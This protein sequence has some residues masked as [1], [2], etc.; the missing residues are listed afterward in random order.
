MDIALMR[1]SPIPPIKT[2]SLHFKLWINVRNVIF[3]SLICFFSTSSHA[4]DLSW[5]P[6]VDSEVEEEKKPDAAQDLRYG[7]VLYH[8]FQQ[9]YFDALTELMVGQ[10]KGDIIFHRDNAE[11]LRGG[12][13]LSYGLDR[14]AEPIFQRLLEKNRDSAERDTAWFYL[15]KLQHQR[16][17]DSQS[18]KALSQLSGNLPP[19]LTQESQSLKAN[20]LLQQGDLVSA[21]QVI[22]SLP[23]E[24]VWYPYYFYNL[25]VL[26]T[27]QGQWQQGVESL[28]RIKSLP[29]NSDELKILRDKAS[30]AIG[31]SY[32]TGGQYP[33][34]INSFQ[35]VRIN[36]PMVQKALLGYGWAEAQRGNYQAALSPWQKLSQLS[37]LNASVQESLLAIPY[38]YEKLNAAGSA[39]AYYENSV[40]KLELELKRLKSAIAQFESDPINELFSINSGFSD[41]WFV[42]DNL[43][44]NASSRNN[45]Y[46]SHLI[47]KNDFQLALKN[48][49]DMA[50]LL[51]NLHRARE[52]ALV[53]D[54]V[55]KD[56]LATWGKIV[57]QSQYQ[58][59]QDRQQALLDERE[60]LNSK[61]K[62]A[63]NVGDGFS[64]ADVQ[65]KD[66]WSRVQRVEGNLRFLQ[67]N[68]QTISE[69]V[70]KYR[71]L[72][73]MLVWKNSEELPQRIWDAKKQQRE[74]D[75][76]LA[77]TELAMASLLTAIEGYNQ[78]NFEQRM[79]TITERL[80]SSESST[81]MLLAESEQSLRKLAVSELSLQKTRLSAYI[82]QARL[83]IARLY[84][85]GSMEGS[86]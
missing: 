50:G 8:F 36:S 35:Q 42:S 73:G 1:P 44:V 39:L 20:I 49:R 71:L 4:I 28:S 12:M 64:L 11:L 43:I 18:Y 33:Q 15:A 37:L 85:A 80:F 74:L 13:S 57:E 6:F 72:R 19:L 60:L 41:N 66:L 24:S 61:I 58:Q 67:K 62:Q 52:K 16:G 55:H 40:T 2:P 63:V 76:A 51:Q 26:Q 7:V 27:I 30:T 84:D 10:E 46:L 82:G 32:L 23:P 56:Q 3:A 29:A 31:F 21:E 86:Q 14:Q 70:E 47:S 54:G 81:R 59:F 9:S 69:E 22:N 77:Q 65:G 45:L 78:S 68:E 75:K 5:I 83:S 38:A 34:A 79:V 48:H 25:G 53:M 17:R